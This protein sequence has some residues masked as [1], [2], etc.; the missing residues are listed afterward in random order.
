[1]SAV[2]EEPT[3][4]ENRQRTG[5]HWIGLRLEKPG[6]NRF[7][8]GARVSVSA[9]GRRQLREVRS[10]GSYVSQNELRAHFGLGAHIG[11]VDVE[12]IMPGGR[13]WRFPQ[14]ATDRLHVLKLE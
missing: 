12:V 11:P 4:L 13:S 14:L 10:G 5:N 1:M 2:D 6:K 3:L 9:G 8:I 7:A